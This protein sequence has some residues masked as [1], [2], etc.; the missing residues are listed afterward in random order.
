MLATMREGNERSR[1][2][3]QYPAARRC[4]IGSPSK[5]DGFLITEKNR[6]NDPLAA[7]PRAVV[8]GRYTWTTRFFIVDAVED[9]ARLSSFRLSWRPLTSPTWR[10]SKFRTRKCSVRF[11]HGAMEPLTGSAGL[12]RRI[13]RA[14]IQSFYLIS[15]DTNQS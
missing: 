4:P 1:E 9:V 10:S 8:G 12:P 13:A 14:E 11:P 6:Q 5:I 15:F 7:T 2:Y 3:K